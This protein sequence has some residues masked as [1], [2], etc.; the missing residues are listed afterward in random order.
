[1]LTPASSRSTIPHGH[2]HLNQVV[3]QTIYQPP[4]PGKFQ[5]AHVHSTIHFEGDERHTALFHDLRIDLINVRESEFKALG[6]WTIDSNQSR[7][8]GGW[9]PALTQAI[10]LS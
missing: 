3:C 1:M 2:S 6:G 5:T 7:S 9:I 8:L 10:L 4:W